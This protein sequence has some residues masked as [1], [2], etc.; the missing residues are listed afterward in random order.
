M[1]ASPAGWS[2]PV[3]GREFHPLKSSAFHGALL[4]QQLAQFGTLLNFNS[5]TENLPETILRRDRCSY[6]LQFGWDSS[7]RQ[8]AFSVAACA[9]GC[10]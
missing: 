2:E 10:V 1:Y 7:D 3:P 5:H 4:R 9:P 8:F 6:S